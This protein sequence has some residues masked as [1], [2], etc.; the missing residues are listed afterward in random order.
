MLVTLKHRKQS[1]R[2]HETSRCLKH[3][4]SH[5]NN[6]NTPW[7]HDYTNAQK[8]QH[9]WAWQGRYQDRTKHTNINKAR[10]L[11]LY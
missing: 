5:N 7:T 4:Y 6:V 11:T 2:E 3:T 10:Q 1:E 9:A 8:A